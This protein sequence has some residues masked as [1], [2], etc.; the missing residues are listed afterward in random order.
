[1][2][3]RY[4]REWERGPQKK[5][6]DERVIIE[7]HWV[8]LKV[9]PEMRTWRRLKSREQ[10]GGTRE[11]EIKGKSQLEN[12][13]LSLPRHPLRKVATYC[14]PGL[15][16]TVQNELSTQGLTERSNDP[17]ILFAP[18]VG[19]IHGDVNSLRPRG[20]SHLLHDEHLLTSSRNKELG[21]IMWKSHWTC[22]RGVAVSVKWAQPT[23][24]VYCSHR[25]HQWGQ[26]PGG[27]GS[28]DVCSAQWEK[29]QLRGMGGFCATGLY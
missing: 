27:P 5:K 22:M 13:F 24:T 21:G 28:R 19:T 26:K 2:I 12:V 10:Q 16:R 9:K 14:H 29:L 11:R 7:E 1:M 20:F 6:E 8:P 15:P 18:L 25:G 4:W 17:L 23:W 3:P